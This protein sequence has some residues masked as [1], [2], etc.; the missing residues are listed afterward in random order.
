MTKW[1]IVLELGPSSQVQDAHACYFVN[2]DFV[3]ELGWHY[4]LKGLAQQIFHQL[5]IQVWPIFI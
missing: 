2:S 5:F 3:V 1:M 4:E